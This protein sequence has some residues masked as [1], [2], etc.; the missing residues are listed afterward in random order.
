MHDICDGLGR[1]LALLRLFGPAS[2]LH[3]KTIVVNYSS[4]T[5]EA[6]SEMIFDASLE[7]R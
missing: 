4:H 6:L 7:V 1:L 5:D 3:A 2:G